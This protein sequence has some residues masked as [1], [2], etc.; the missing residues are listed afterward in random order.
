MDSSIDLLFSFRTFNCTVAGDTSKSS[1]S[2]VPNRVNLSL[3]QRD[4][5]ALM[6]LAKL[7]WKNN[8]K[9]TSVACQILTDYLT[10]HLDRIIDNEDQRDNKVSGVLKR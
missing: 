10:D 3:H 8:T 2:N 5:D 9:V 7:R 6:A 1:S 4:Y